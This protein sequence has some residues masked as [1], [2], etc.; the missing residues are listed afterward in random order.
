MDSMGMVVNQF[1]FVQNLMKNSWIPCQAHLWGV[2]GAWGARKYHQGYSISMGHIEY[3]QESG[4][5]ILI[6]LQYLQD[7]DLLQW[8]E[9]Q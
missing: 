8:I 1:R 3:F 2:R 7:P 9:V 6:D 5:D 4:L